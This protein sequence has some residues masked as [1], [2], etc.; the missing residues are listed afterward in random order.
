[1]IYGLNEE[2]RREVKDVELQARLSD[3]LQNSQNDR[4]EW[5]LDLQETGSLLNEAKQR[6]RGCECGTCCECRK[7]APGGQSLLNLY[8]PE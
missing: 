8:L 6:R 5:S 1:M 4:S 7:K 3:L 2:E